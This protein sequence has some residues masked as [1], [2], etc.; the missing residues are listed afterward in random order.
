MT[1]QDWLR[2]TIAAI[3]AMEQEQVVEIVTP[4]EQEDLET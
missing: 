4:E 2:E 3:E 1:F